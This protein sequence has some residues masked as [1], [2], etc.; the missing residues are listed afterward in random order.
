M[1]AEGQGISCS[2][3]GE[4]MTPSLRKFVAIGPESTGKSTLCA[5][6]ARYYNTDWCPE[7]AREY[8]EAHGSHYNFD[9]LL[10]IARGQI[11]LETSVATSVLGAGSNHL[12]FV[13]T[14]MHVM[15]VWCEYVFHDCHRWIL[16]QI[17]ERRYDG[18][19]LC[20]PDLPWEDDELREY[21]DQKTRDELFLF[22]QE[23]LTA[24]SVPWIPIRGSH[25]QRLQS[26]ISLVASVTSS[27]ISE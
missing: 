19:F 20:A 18:Y 14:D 25:Q 4:I 22:Y 11:D 15:R 26:A 16:D 17:A 24:E 5:D 3:P 8:L 12:L 27:T 2:K 1:A 13:D 9:T 6:L 10:D 21:P 7:Y 23:I